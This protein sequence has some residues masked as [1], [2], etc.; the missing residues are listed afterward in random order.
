MRVGLRRED[1]LC[2]VRLSDVANEI[3][4]ELK[5]IQPLSIV[6]RFTSVKTLFSSILMD[7]ETPMWYSLP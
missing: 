5:Y 4:I 6:D 7:R 1:T 3:A 2:R